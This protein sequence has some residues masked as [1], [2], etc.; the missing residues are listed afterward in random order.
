MES[1]SEEAG[2]SSEPSRSV[3]RQQS[4]LMCVYDFPAD[5]S[6]KKQ[7]IGIVVNI[8][9]FQ[10][11]LWIENEMD[12]L[13]IFDSC[14]KQRWV[15]VLT[16]NPTCEGQSCPIQKISSFLGVLD[17]L[18]GLTKKNFIA[19]VRSFV[20]LA[21]VQN[22]NVGLFSETINAKKFKLGRRVAYDKLYISHKF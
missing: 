3:G 20:R 21:C 15:Y 1:A 22:L 19:S 7:Q 5:L 17:H 18:K 12:P 16:Q 4:F 10:Y 6:S 11:I 8:R 2:D 13:L 14:A 9:V